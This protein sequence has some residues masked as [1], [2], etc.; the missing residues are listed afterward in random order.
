METSTVTS[1]DIVLRAIGEADL[2]FLQ[3]VISD[4]EDEGSFMWQGFRDPHES[5]P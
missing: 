3:N 2:S 1:D 5:H 4:P